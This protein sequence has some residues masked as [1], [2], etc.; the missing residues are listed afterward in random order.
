MGMKLGIGASLR[1][2]R[3][4]RAMVST[5]AAPGRYDPLGVLVPMAADFDPLGITALHVFTFNQV[6]N[7]VAWQI[8]VGGGALFLD[9]T[10]LDNTE[11]V[12]QRGLS[13]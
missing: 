4:N 6:A 9:N 13:V 1:Y 12:D 7:T 2:L 8:D 5:L 11:E 10:G 3:K